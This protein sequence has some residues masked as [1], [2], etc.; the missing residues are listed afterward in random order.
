MN[1]ILKKVIVVTAIMNMNVIEADTIDT[2]GQAPYE[3]CGYCH[4][5]DGNSLMP[6]YPKLAEQVPAYIKKQLQDFRDGRRKGQMQATAEL[7][8]DEDIEIVASYFSQQKLARIT[9]PSLNQTQWEMATSLFFKG[10]KSR[11]IDACIS[12]H[13]SAAQGIG[14]FPR[15]AGQHQAYLAQQLRDFK[16]GARA[17]DEK[18]VMQEL[19]QKLSEAEIDSV[20]GYLSGITT[21][22]QQSVLEKTYINQ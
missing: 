14:N 21:T 6:S 18:G 17:N 19:A 11:G 7:L 13:S 15:L 16:T 9:N 2:S 22:E 10:D 5:F 8:S 3:Q 4:E 12:C 1:N 20:S